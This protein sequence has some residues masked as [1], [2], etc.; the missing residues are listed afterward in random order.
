[1][2]ARVLELRRTLEDLSSKFYKLSRVKKAP[3]LGGGPCGSGAA[4]SP[5]FQPGNTCAKGGGAPVPKDQAYDGKNWIPGGAGKMSGVDTS[6]FKKGHANTDWAL[7][8]IYA[9]EEAAAKGDWDTFQK[10]WPGTKDKNPNK[11]HKAV[12]AAEANLLKWKDEQNKSL[13]V[14]A[15]PSKTDPNVAGPAGWKKVGGQLGTEK[16][17][18]YEMGGKKYY[19]KTPD[20]V[21]R[22]HNE[23]LALKLYEAA[24][25]NA[26]KGNM[27]EIDGTKSVATEWLD[28]KK[29][30][31]SD[32]AQKVLA[33]DDFAIHAWLNNWDA[34][35]HISEMDNIRFGNDG[36]MT[37]VDAGGSLDYKAHGGGGKKDLTYFADEWAT[38]RDPKVNP[39]M[40]KVFGDMTP[41]QL[42]KSAKKLE[43]V[44]D[45]QIEDLVNNHSNKTGTDRE[46]LI[47]KLKK[48]KAIILNKAKVLDPDAFDLGSSKLKPVD[49]DDDGP[50]NL[51]DD[52]YEITPNNIPAPIVTGGK[53]SAA[54]ATT[55]MAVPPPPVGVTYFKNKF[56]SIYEAAKKDG[57]VGV[58]AI[59]TNSSPDASANAKA[60]H[61]YKQDV[62]AALQSGGQV[63]QSHQ[64]VA[65]TVPKAVTASAT[66]VKIDPAKF[67]LMPT[68]VNSDK[69]QVAQNNDAVSQSLKHAE[70]GDLTALK[71]MPLPPSPKLQNWHATLVQNLASQLN[72]PPPLKTIND[73]LDSIVKK[74]GVAKGK[75]GLQAVGKWAVLSDLGGVPTQTPKSNYIDDIDKLDA[76]HAEGNKA[77]SKSGAKSLLKDYTGD[78]S[79]S[80]NA[81]LRNPDFAKDNP[82]LY[83]KALKAANAIMKHGVELEEGAV[84]VRTHAPINVDDLRPGQVVSDKGM[85]S[86]SIGMIA[87]AGDKVHW[88]LTAGPGVKGMP[89]VDF[90]KHYT[91]GEVILAPNQRMLVTKVEKNTSS[92][93]GVKGYAQSGKD[94]I[95][96]IILPTDPNQCCPP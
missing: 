32:P 77:A 57:M 92:S 21:N 27:V 89:A 58:D 73:S 34:V 29:A 17:G 76:I 18:T 47:E 44:T 90:S 61:K 26:V 13:P 12:M 62:L 30:N 24:G 56:D 53:G 5:G 20:N 40:A 55:K 85:L 91:E 83:N 22:A 81:A 66:P 94:V 15:T 69:T 75:T 37:L 71:N 2:N 86:T 9:M 50:I 41:A 49:D 72:P 48:R 52:D 6:S 63:S 96:A 4:G 1:M 45:K 59:K 95:H 35:G 54:T 84:I 10:A 36:K 60:L 51:V 7:K 3:P 11:F 80:F 64:Q 78:F 28:S 31:L 88:H 46:I 39:S 93:Y 70:A 79:S 19:V 8:K 43:M 14:G 23:V 82:D 16:G 68:F 65:Q 42:V 38:L 67:P 25:A 33:Q 74:V 87:F